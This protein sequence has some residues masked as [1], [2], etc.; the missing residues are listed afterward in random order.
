MDNIRQELGDRRDQSKNKQVA[1]LAKERL[2]EALRLKKNVL[3]DAT[4]IRKDHREELFTIATN[5]G[6]VTQLIVLLDKESNIRLKNKNRTYD[7][8]DEVITRMK[9]SFQYPN[10]LE[11]YSTKY[12]IYR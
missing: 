7:V 3:W 5:Y 12:V 11:A 2:K 10:P 4:S 6:A 8:P 1:S 9:D